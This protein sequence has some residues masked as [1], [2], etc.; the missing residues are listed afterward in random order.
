MAENKEV[1]VEDNKPK[2]QFYKGNGPAVSVVKTELNASLSTEKPSMPPGQ[3][4]LVK[5]LPHTCFH[6]SRMVQILPRP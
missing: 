4:S 2:W 5:R 3:T 6:H 1:K